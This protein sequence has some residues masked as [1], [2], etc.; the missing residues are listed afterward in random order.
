[1]IDLGPGAGKL[2]GRVI[3]QGHAD[4][5]ASQPDPL[6]GRFL[7]A[8]RCA[9]RCFRAATVASSTSKCSARRCTT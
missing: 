2:G 8:S 9:I 3:A 1:V 5:L 7:R 6:T 4:D